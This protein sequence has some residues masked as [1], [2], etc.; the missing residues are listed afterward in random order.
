MQI[1]PDRRA[2]AVQIALKMVEATHKEEGC[3]AY[4]FY[5]PLDDPNTFFVYEEWATEEALSAHIQ[6]EHM[7]EFQQRLP[8]TLAGEVDVKKYTV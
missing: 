2:E 1:A 6:S 8:A 7:K 3:L 5:S 4:T